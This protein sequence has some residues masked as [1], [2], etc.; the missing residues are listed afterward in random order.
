MKAL[1]A[2]RLIAIPRNTPIVIYHVRPDVIDKGHFDSYSTRIL[3]DLCRCRRH[4]F[5]LWKT[6]LDL[7]TK[8]GCYKKVR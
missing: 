7:E 4:G 5:L 6:R 3:T 1:A 2:A 8:A